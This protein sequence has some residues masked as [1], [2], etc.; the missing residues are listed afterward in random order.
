M[1]HVP[2]KA[3]KNGNGKGSDSRISDYKAY[4]TRHSEINWKKDGK[5]HTTT[6]I[7]LGKHLRGEL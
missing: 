1:A 4:R 3:S 7:I 5:S 6:T 2:K